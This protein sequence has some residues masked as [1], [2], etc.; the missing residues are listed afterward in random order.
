MRKINTEDAIVLYSKTI[1]DNF[2]LHTNSAIKLAQIYPPQTDDRYVSPPS[3]GHTEKSTGEAGFKKALQRMRGVFKSFK[4]SIDT[5]VNMRRENQKKMM[6]EFRR[7]KSRVDSV[8]NAYQGKH[9][10]M[11]LLQKWKQSLDAAAQSGQMHQSDVHKYLE[12]GLQVIDSI[13]LKNT[14]TPEV[15]PFKKPDPRDNFLAAPPDVPEDSHLVAPPDV[16][17]DSYLAAPSDAPQSSYLAAPRTG[18]RTAVTPQPQAPAQQAKKPSFLSKLKNRFKRTKS[19]ANGKFYK[20]ANN[21]DVWV[22]KIANDEMRPKHYTLDPIDKDKFPDREREGLEGPIRLKN[23][24]TVY[25][26]KQEGKYYNPRTDMYLDY[27]E[28]EANNR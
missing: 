14:T 2:L 4:D 5:Y 12:T 24:L 10:N 6:F 18:P 1:V 3:V 25:Y 11:G 8:F 22:W 16:T 20:V 15:K 17:E 28:Y 27:E 13:L 23:G 7:M 26:D 19:S 9:E 21:E